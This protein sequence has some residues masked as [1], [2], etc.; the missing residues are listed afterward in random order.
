MLGVVVL[1][2]ES[3]ICFN[4]DAFRARISGDLIGVGSSVD[5]K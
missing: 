3:G 5:P 2:C 1:I 4:Y